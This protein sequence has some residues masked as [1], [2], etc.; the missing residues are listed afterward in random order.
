MLSPATALASD[1]SFPG[2]FP[3]VTP[4]GSTVPANG[5]LNP[6]G[7]VTV[8]RSTGSLVRGDLLISNF[9]DAKNALDLLH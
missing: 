6:Y 2:R 1:H 8:P 9:N 7:I 4:I 5:D 3:T